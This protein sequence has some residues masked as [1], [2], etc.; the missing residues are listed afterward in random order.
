ML[1]EESLTELSKELE[2]LPEPTTQEEVDIYNGKIKDYEKELATYNNFVKSSGATF[3]K[4]EE[5]Q[6]E[7]E[8]LQADGE[9]FNLTSEEFNKNIKRF[10]S[11][12]DAIN[13]ERQE[14]MGEYGFTVMDGMMKKTS[15]DYGSIKEYE[16]WR[17]K[18]KITKGFFDIDTYTT[19]GQG[20]LNTGAKY[21]T[22][23]S[24]WGLNL[25]DG[26]TGGAISGGDE[27]YTNYDYFGKAQAGDYEEGEQGFFDKGADAIATGLP[28]MLAIAASSGKEAFKPGMFT[29]TI[30][31]KLLDVDFAN[32][33]RAAQT[34]FRLTAMD[35]TLEGKRKPV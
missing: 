27:K 10:E 25:L 26:V 28:F 6:K 17:K 33:I 4:Y 9:K 1:K 24:L 8:L 30:G 14:I 13:S 7:G 15:S 35:N 31:K 16:E 5:L 34:G 19:L 12:Y 3:K 20:L 22:G 18:N 2:G 23:T 32:K 11:E 29:K 21:Y